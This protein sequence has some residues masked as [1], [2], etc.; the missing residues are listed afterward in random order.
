MRVINNEGLTKLKGSLNECFK[1][2]GVVGA[3]IIIAI[4]RDSRIKAKQS[5]TA[6][7]HS[8]TNDRV[9]RVVQEKSRWGV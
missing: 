9:W 1:I 8:F 2:R 7:W 6:V 3:T 4:A 5:T